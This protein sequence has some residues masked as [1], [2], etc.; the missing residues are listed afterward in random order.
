MKDND[1]FRS[2]ADKKLEA[3]TRQVTVNSHQAVNDAANDLS[4][5]KNGSP[6]PPRQHAIY[7]GKKVTLSQTSFKASSAKSVPISN[8]IGKLAKP[9]QDNVKASVGEST[10]EQQ[11]KTALKA[12]N[13]VRHSA[14]Y[15]LRGAKVVARVPKKLASAITRRRAIS[16]KARN[17]AR[18][19]KRSQIVLAPRQKYH[20]FGFGKYAKTR[21]AYKRNF[22]RLR[23]S[24]NG[25]YRIA[26]IGKSAIGSVGNA[27]KFAISKPTDMLGNK[28][29]SQ[30]ADRKTSGD[31]G[32]QTVK[33]GLQ[34]A[35][36]ARRGV[37]GVK[38]L[39][40]APKKIFN[41][42]KRTVKAT[43][44]TVKTTVKAAR[45]TA[46]AAKTTIKVTAKMVKAVV[47]TAVKVVTKVVSIIVET[48]PWS[49]IIIGAIL[50]ILLVVWG[51]TLIVESI[52][53]SAK[54]VAGWAIP[55][56]S[57][58]TSFDGR[59]VYENIVN[60]S[61]DLEDVYDDVK[62]SLKN[63]VNGMSNYDYLGYYDDTHSI[64]SVYPA[65]SKKAEINGYIDNQDINTVDI[66]AALFVL[67]T[68][69]KQ[70]ENATGSD[71]YDDTE[72]FDIKFSKD[73]FK[74]FVGNVNNNSNKYG[75]A[76]VYKTTEIIGNL[77][78]PGQNCTTLYCSSVSS[79]P[80]PVV[81]QTGPNSTSSYCP[82][83]GTYCPGHHRQLTI[84]LQNVNDIPSTYN[85]TQN[86]KGRYEA[87]KAFINAMLDMYGG[88]TD[89][90]NS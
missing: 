25:I 5:K 44:R 26:N 17:L 50:L 40:K 48:A 38:S 55:S 32:A 18:R 66:L 51:I 77:K 1:L 14:R 30:R 70:K 72:A 7:R 41:G 86:E 10:S 42:A 89:E 56:D 63:A 6:Q 39:A 20:I 31:M 83:H 60:L 71:I 53:G 65:Y 43:T 68:R 85:F 52:G 76:I 67:M 27:A 84:K 11:A 13:F 21:L 59:D 35:D 87:C 12:A 61:E 88:E 69:D 75:D 54:S 78:C 23:L 19:L 64:Y 34:T 81:I 47:Q 82:G 33:L 46:R 74:E 24:Q 4:E 28:L 58:I 8:A 36:Y 22:R 49:L 2:T 29:L 3:E 79:C 62:L 80:S 37:R 45:A 16:P 73:D 57:S 9:L 90:T 15:G